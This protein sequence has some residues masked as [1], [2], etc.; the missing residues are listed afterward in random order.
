[1]GRRR[2]QAPAP[3]KA[4]AEVKGDGI[5]L[6][7]TSAVRDQGGFLTVNG[8]VTNGTGASGS[9]ATGGVTS[10][11]EQERLLA[12]GSELVDSGEEEVPRPSGRRGALPV[13]EVHGRRHRGRRPTG[14]PSSR[15]LRRDSKVTFQVGHAPRSIEISEGE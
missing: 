5:T 15:L 8:T 1:M 10:G 12:G 9:A 6:K 13:Y 11:A 2:T 3:D 7:V 4:L 14:S